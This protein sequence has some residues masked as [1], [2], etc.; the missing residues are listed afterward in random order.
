MPW[1]KKHSSVDFLSDLTDVDVPAPNPGEVLTYVGP[2]WESK[3]AS[4]SL[5]PPGAA[6]DVLTSDGANWV[7]LPLSSSGVNNASG[8]PGANVTQA[9][10]ALAPLA[11]PALTGTPTS[12]TAPPGTNTSQIAT[13]AFVI[14]EISDRAPIA[15]PHLT[16]VPT[17]PTAAPGTNTTQIATT[18]FVTTGLSGKQDA[19]SPGNAEDILV[20]TGASYVP[21][22]VVSFLQNRNLP[23]FMECL[24]DPSASGWSRSIVGTGQFGS[25]SETLS[26]HPGQWFLRVGSGTGSRAAFYLCEATKGVFLPDDPMVGYFETMIQIPVLSSGAELFEQFIGF[27]DAASLIGVNNGTYFYI[28]TANELYART[29]VGGVV[30]DDVFTTTLNASSWYRFR[31]EM[32][33]TQTILSWAETSDRQAPLATALAATKVPEAQGPQIKIVRQNGTSARDIFIDYMAF[34]CPKV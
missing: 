10:D 19:L 33:G 27:V 34:Y 7:G 13:T 21:T 28:D 6:G 4:G 24:T 18:A 29:I 12:P 31:A 32:L 30:V 23:F 14:T 15:S 9:L 11:S 22:D 2:N 26:D 8:V 16:G 25:I 1:C 3:P 20:S 5:P 17:S